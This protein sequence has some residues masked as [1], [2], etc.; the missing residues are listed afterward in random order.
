MDNSQ[1]GQ[2]QKK[3]ASKSTE[4]ILE[5]EK[6]EV[7]ELKARLQK[8]EARL[9]QRLRKERNGQLVALGVLAE[10]IYK[11]GGQGA[12]LLKESAQASLKDRNL[13]RVGAA[14]ARLDKEVKPDG[15]A[16]QGDTH[17]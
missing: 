9:N 16:A 13:E 8:K 12:K 7:A 10:I 6:K 17:G 15:Q 1:N 4:E 5:K 2:P 3:R 14:F 11:A